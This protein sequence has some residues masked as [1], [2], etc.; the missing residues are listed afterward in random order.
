MARKQQFQ[1][2]S[3]VVQ[4]ELWTVIESAGDVPEQ[5]DLEQ[6]WSILDVALDSLSVRSQ[7]KLAGDVIDRMAQIIHDRA[8][9][10]IAEIHHI[11][12]AEGPIMPLGAFDR[13]VRQSMQVNLAPFVEGPP[14]PP[15]ASQV[16][17]PSDFPDDGRSVVA[18]IDQAALLEALETEPELDELESYQ[19]AL[20]LAHS[21]NVQ[22]WMRAIQQCF[23]AQ[24]HRS[25]LWVD[26]TRAM[27]DLG[28]AE[29]NEPQRVWVNTW[30]ALLLGEYR[31][32]QRGEF[33]GAE[34]LWV[35]RD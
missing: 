12:T 26:L 13:F 23:A 34:T 1:R 24:P 22:D 31:L 15:R 16:G 3:Q 6:I 27:K 11:G 9:S 10:T 8:L 32:E 4:L 29:E 5:A 14:S 20:A 17:N 18:E 2:S 19:G 30:L 35:T 21:E 28:T 25:M 33:Y 7:L